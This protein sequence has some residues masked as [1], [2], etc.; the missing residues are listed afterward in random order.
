MLTGGR[1]AD[2]EP[3]GAE[4][5]AAGR[6][7][8]EEVHPPGHPEEAQQTAH[9]ATFQR[10]LTRPSSDSHRLHLKPRLELQLRGFCRS[11][12]RRSSSPPSAPSSQQPAQ[13]EG[14]A[15][16]GQAQS[17]GG[18]G[19]RGGRA[20][21]RL[22]GHIARLNRE[23]FCTRVSE[24]CLNYLNVIYFLC[25]GGNLGSSICLHQMC[26]YEPL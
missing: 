8:P 6:A 15:E 7:G 26:D 2:P 14:Q 16:E 17:P 19:A 11:G 22:P 9:A 10:P 25:R 12:P 1:S 5:A 3:A 18:A 20:G 23:G 4:P 24:M 21:Q 13:L